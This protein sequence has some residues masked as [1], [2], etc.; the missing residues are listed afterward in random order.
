MLT[1]AT[2]LLASGYRAGK[3]LAS[4]SVAN[5]KKAMALG[6]GLGTAGILA[7][8]TKSIYQSL[9]GNKSN[10]M[11]TSPDSSY[12]TAPSDM[13]KKGMYIYGE[14]PVT[15]IAIGFGANIGLE[16]LGGEKGLR[17]YAMKLYQAD[18]AGIDPKY[19][20]SYAKEM[21][22]TAAASRAASGA[23]LG[24]RIWQG[25]KNVARAS[26][27]DSDAI[28]ATEKYIARTPGVAGSAAGKK[29]LARI[30]AISKAKALNNIA[31]FGWAV[32]MAYDMGK[33]FFT[34]SMPAFNVPTVRTTALGGTFNDSSEAYTQRRRA[35]EAMHNSQYSGRSAFGNEAS[36]MH[37]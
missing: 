6:V 2:S 25:I 31:S 14:N 5:P 9:S 30:G 18:K 29:M 24:S 23:S 34:G 35:I 20:L 21:R 16:K 1:L 26:R 19:Y 27:P 10:T 22:A 7:A 36:L 3:S 28:R 32:S 33:S 15:A 4:Y 8:N 13:I 12:F 17:K 11:D 37:A